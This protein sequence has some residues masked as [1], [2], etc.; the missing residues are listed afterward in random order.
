MPSLREIDPRIP[1]PLEAIVRKCLRKDP[2]ERYAD[3][4]E[5]RARPRLLA[6]PGPVDVRRSARRSRPRRPRAG[7]PLLV[8]GISLGFLAASVLFVLAVYLLTHH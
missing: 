3:A 7:L 4:G 1:P 2:D 6:G 5:L 8:A